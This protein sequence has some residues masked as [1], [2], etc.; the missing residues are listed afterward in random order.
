MVFGLVLNDST[1]MG[2]PDIEALDI[3]KGLK[4]LIIF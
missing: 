1:E 4:I 3:S 2:K